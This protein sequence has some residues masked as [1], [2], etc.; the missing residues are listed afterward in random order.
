MLQLNIVALTALTRLVLP[1]M[2]QR[3]WGRILN[4]ASIV[5]YQPAGPRMTADYAT[6]AYVLAFSK[7]LARELSGGGVSVT[8]SG[9][10]VQRGTF[11]GHDVGL[12][13]F[14]THPARVSVQG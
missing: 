4:V 6:K 13:A 10:L 11:P 7:G 12:A 9:R 14:A 5:S 3:R 2:R 1:G 8:C